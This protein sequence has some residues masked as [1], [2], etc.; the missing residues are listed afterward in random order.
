MRN[1]CELCEQVTVK[2]RVTQDQGQL[3]R[4]V[5]TNVDTTRNALPP[6]RRHLT[7]GIWVNGELWYTGDFDPQKFTDKLKKRYRVINHQ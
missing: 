3:Y 6:N 4:L 2:L 1:S 5:V 7:P